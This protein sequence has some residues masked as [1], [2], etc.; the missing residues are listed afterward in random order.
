MPSSGT[1][2]HPLQPTRLGRSFLGIHS[3]PMPAR[4][5]IGA[6]ALIVASF[7]D[8]HVLQIHTVEGVI[9]TIV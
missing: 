5:L 2:N 8:G 7:S 4:Q 1:P 6:G 3:S 9:V